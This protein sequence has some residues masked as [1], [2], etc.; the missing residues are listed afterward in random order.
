[1]GVSWSETIA[2]KGADGLDGEM[3]GPASS[4]DGN[5][6]AFDGVDGTTLKDSGKSPLV[7]LKVAGD[8]PE[9]GGNLDLLT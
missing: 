9:L 6:A 2:V 7:S 3:S 5:F 1:M 8:T 4:T